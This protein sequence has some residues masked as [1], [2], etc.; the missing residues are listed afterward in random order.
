MFLEIGKNRFINLDNVLEIREG[1]GVGVYSEVIFN[2]R[3]A[4]GGVYYLELSGEARLKLLEY[5]KKVNNN[6]NDQ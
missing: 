2:A 3:R 5:L 6:K 4:N 1:G